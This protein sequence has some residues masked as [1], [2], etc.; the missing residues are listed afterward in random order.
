MRA[1]SGYDEAGM[2]SSKRRRSE[3]MKERLLRYSA[4]LL[5]LLLAIAPA[6]GPVAA[7]ISRTETFGQVHDISNLGGSKAVFAWT[8]VDSN[9][10]S[11]V[12]FLKQDSQEI[13][14]T[15]NVDGAF[16]FLQTVDKGTGS[17]S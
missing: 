7:A 13:L 8:A 2:L 9:N 3:S 6:A 5:L 17:L 11:H 12:V 4:S 15:N 1:L 14:Y 10:H 16:D